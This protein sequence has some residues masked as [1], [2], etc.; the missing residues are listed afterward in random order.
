M[1]YNVEIYPQF[2]RE[3]SR[4]SRR[5]PSLKQELSDLFDE[6]APHRNVSIAT[7]KITLS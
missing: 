4:L 7:P 6:L 3:A 1:S 5:Y 2:K